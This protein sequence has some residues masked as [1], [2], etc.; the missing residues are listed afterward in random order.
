MTTLILPQVAFGACYEDDIKNTIFNAMDCKLDSTRRFNHETRW[1]K[2]FPEFTLIASPSFHDKDKIEIGRDYGKWIYMSID[3]I[4]KLYNLIRC[5]FPNGT[6]V[7]RY[8]K[9][10]DVTIHQIFRLGNNVWADPKGQSVFYCEPPVMPVEYN[11]WIQAVTTHDYTYMMSDSP[12]TYKAGVQAEERIKELKKNL[13]TRVCTLWYNYIL[14]RVNPCPQDMSFGDANQA[15]WNT[16]SEAYK[17][18]NISPSHHPY[19]ELG[20]EPT[21]KPCLGF[22]AHA[23]RTG[24]FE[25]D[26]KY[27]GYVS[28]NYFITKEEYDNSQIP[29]TVFHN[30]VEKGKLVSEKYETNKHDLSKVLERH[31]WQ[32]HYY[33]LEPEGILK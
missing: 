15:I 33:T 27:E 22:T 14:G 4:N 29:V 30:Y 5:L 26:M 21:N 32:D 8:K 18:F 10:Y 3:R 7:T 16:L 19:V 12:G 9:T 28:N 31:S 6:F 23:K 24:W 25:D 17:E 11:E 13:D 2:G 1:F 20:I